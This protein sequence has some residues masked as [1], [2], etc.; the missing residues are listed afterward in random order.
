MDI[1]DSKTIKP[2]QIIETKTPFNS[3]DWIYELKL[4]GVRCLAY[5]NSSSTDLRN[6]LGQSLLPRFPELS[7]L[8]L[9]SSEKCILDGELIVIKNGV[10]DFFELQR[11][12]IQSPYSQQSR[13]APFHPASFV[14]YD[15]LYYKDH[16]VTDL[17]LMERKQLLEQLLYETVDLAISRYTE[18]CGTELF[19]LAL[20]EKL[21]GVIAKRKDSNYSINESTTNW[22]RFL[23]I[24]IVKYV[25][26]GILWTPNNKKRILLGQYQ[27][28]A[29]IYKGSVDITT[30]DNKQISLVD[31][32]SHLCKKT[33]V[34]PFSLTPTWSQEYELTWF[35]PQ[36][37]CSVEQPSVGLSK[38]KRAIFRG[39]CEDTLPKECINSPT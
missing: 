23:K 12:L 29:L 39:I 37:V 20:K 17:P 8:H 11:R 6:K 32:V 2:M 31:Y 3:Q 36:I 19:Q 15:I 30:W 24:P 33:P 26:C 28:N 4:D 7:N 5:L 1:F 10:P 35:E 22:V 25:I 27:N 34:S 13:N 16:L 18:E 9:Q 38:H 14:A 21:E